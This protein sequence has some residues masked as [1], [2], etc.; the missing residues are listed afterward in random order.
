[1]FAAAPSDGLPQTADLL[2]SVGDCVKSGNN[3]TFRLG[4]VIGKGECGSGFEAVNV[5]SKR[6]V[7]TLRNN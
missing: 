7:V 4:C 5:E 6:F 2:P 3:L 1:M